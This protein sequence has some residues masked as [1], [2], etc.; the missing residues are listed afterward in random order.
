MGSEIVEICGTPLPKEQLFAIALSVG[1]K[2]AALLDSTANHA[3]VVVH[4]WLSLHPGRTV[5]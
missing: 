4:S 2:A 1:K 5:P 3:H